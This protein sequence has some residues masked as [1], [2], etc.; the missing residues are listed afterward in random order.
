MAAAKMHLC[1]KVC[2][3]KH[4]Y[5]E[6]LIKVVQGEEKVYYI[7]DSMSDAGHAVQYSTDPL[8]GLEPAGILPHNPYPIM[9]APVMIDAK[10]LE[11][12]KAVK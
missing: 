6:L 8:N 11:S 7:I 10:K 5:T 12:P 9:G 4:H 1:S 2:V 3:S